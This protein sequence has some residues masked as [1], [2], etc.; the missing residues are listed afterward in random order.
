MT[1]DSME[2]TSITL[3]CSLS[4]LLSS[5]GDLGTSWVLLVNILDNTGNNSLP[6]VSHSKTTQW[7]VLSKGLNNHRLG[8]N[9]LN[10][11]SITILQELRLLLKSS[12]PEHVNLGPDLSK[13]NS[14]A[15]VAVNTGAYPISNL[16]RMV[17]DDDLGSGWLPP[18]LGHP[19]SL[20][21]HNHA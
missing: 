4:L 9:H 13:L 19:W 6:H 15:S 12:L 2:N 10:H 11:T 18:W 8:G 16:T 3:H 21:Q 5:L 17:H 1:I 7:W 20:R 14:N